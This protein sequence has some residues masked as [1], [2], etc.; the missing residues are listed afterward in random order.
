[1]GAEEVTRALASSVEAPVPA[2]ELRIAEGLD[3]IVLSDNEVLVQ[4]GSRSYPSQLLRDTDLTGILGTVFGLLTAGPKRRDDL[5]DHVEPE[6]RAEAAKLV[7]RLQDAGILARTRTSPVDQYLAY[8]FTGQTDLAANSISL[9][10]A[11]PI[12]ARIAETLLQHGIGQVRLLEG[13][14]PDAVWHTLVQARGGD[15]SPPA[16][17]AQ[18]MLRDRLRDLGYSGVEAVEGDVDDASVARAVA[19]SDLTVVAL[20][21]LDIRIAHLVNRLCIAAAKPWLHVVLDGG[22]S[23]AGPLFVPGVTACYNDFRTLAEA[24]DA[25]PLMARVYRNHVA[26]RGAATFLPGL[27]AHAEIVSGFASLAVVHQ[28][29]AGTSY[30]LGRALTISFDRMM[31]DVEDVLK[32]PRCPVCGQLRN[33]YQPPFSAEVVTRV[34]PAGGAADAR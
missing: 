3:A 33:A 22:R 29:L 23:V 32:L 4:F 15:G 1:V 17:S 19:S 6:H 27:P 24:A 13:R 34:P 14:A 10:G 12:G 18:A 21:Q 28:L 8:T 30:L 7:D 2:D 20:E 16:G 11:G 5:L 25:S 31:I 9:I 26:R